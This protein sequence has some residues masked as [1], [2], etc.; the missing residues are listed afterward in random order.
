MIEEKAGGQRIGK[1]T[2]QI[3]DA[4]DLVLSG[5][6]VWFCACSRKHVRY[7]FFL[8]QTLPA[9]KSMTFKLPSMEVRAGHCFLR[10]VYPGT[11]ARSATAGMRGVVR[12]D[13]AVG[14]VD[15]DYQGERDWRDVADYL[16]SQ[17][18]RAS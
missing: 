3:N 10:F 14:N 13:H 6:N 8:A 7:C 11:H 1:T 9:A 18:G 2:R 4:L 16:R 12:F 5:T 17:T 15:C